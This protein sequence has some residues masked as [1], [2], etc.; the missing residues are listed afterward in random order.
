MG[1]K[2]S[3]ISTLALIPVIICTYQCTFTD[4]FVRTLHVSLRN[5]EVGHG[6][7]WGPEQSSVVH[8]DNAAV[9]A[10][11]QINVSSSLHT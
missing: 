1:R 4:Q 8:T 11:P 10:V 5:T 3:G 9:T 7:G 2:E 6:G